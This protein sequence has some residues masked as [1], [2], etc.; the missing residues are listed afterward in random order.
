MMSATKADEAH[1]YTLSVFPALLLKY[2]NAMDD[3]HW[4]LF[5]SR[6]C[7]SSR[8]LRTSSQNITFKFFYTD[9]INLHFCRTAVFAPNPAQ[10]P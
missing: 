9:F 2:F 1:P 6:C 4:R 10:V 8:L 3:W 5:F 7:S